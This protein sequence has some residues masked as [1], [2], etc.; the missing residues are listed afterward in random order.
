M[1]YP[2]AH[3]EWRQKAVDAVDTQPP[4]ENIARIRSVLGYTVTDV[5]GLL[6][7]SRQA[8]YDWQ[9]GK[10]IGPQNAARLSEVTRAADAIAR[11]GVALTLRAMRRPIRD[12]KNFF[13]LV[14][15]GDSAEDSARRLIE[16]VRG[17]T[18]EREALQTR[19]ARRARPGREA[20]EDIG[21]PMLDEKA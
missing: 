2:Y 9:A 6:G 4:G 19:L 11:E 5:A 3:Y 21:S 16:L 17:E 12:G 13:E 1:G 10:A 20:F 14:R 15:G 7:V 8:I 18:R